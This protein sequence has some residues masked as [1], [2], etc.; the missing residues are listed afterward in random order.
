MICK[1][2]IH[3][4]NALQVRK[5]RYFL[6][7]FI[8]NSHL[9]KEIIVS[10]IYSPTSHIPKQTPVLDYHEKYASKV[11]GVITAIA[12]GIIAAIGAFILVPLLTG[13]TC[14]G[15]WIGTTGLVAGVFSL[16]A[17]FASKKIAEEFIRIM[18]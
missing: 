9:T 18:K 4:Y 14:L 2:D 13:T 12:I 17:Y 6:I 15:M 5:H 8:D 10:G 16:G 11:I 1:I 7:C 3:H